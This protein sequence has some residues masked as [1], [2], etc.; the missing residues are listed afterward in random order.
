MYSKGDL[1]AD[2]FKIFDIFGGEKKSGFGVVYACFDIEDQ[3]FLALKTFQDKY[4]EDKIEKNNFKR[5]ALSWITL[6]KHPFIVQAYHYSE[7][8]YRPYI[9]L[10]LIPF[11]NDGRNILS[12]FLGFKHSLDQILKWAI[13]FCYG[14]EYAESKGI[15]PHL[16]IK[17]DNIMITPEKNIKITDFGLSKLLDIGK[18]IKKH[19]EDSENDELDFLKSSGQIKGALPWI[20]PE[21]FSGNS[22]IKS[23]IYSFGII[24]YQLIHEGYHPFGYLN[25]ETNVEWRSAH[26]N[27]DFIPFDGPLFPIVDKCLQ[28]DYDSRYNTFKDLRK[29]LEA[30]YTNEIE[31][32]LPV[33][34][35]VSELEIWEVRAKATS[36]YSLK[37]YD[38]AI[39]TCEKAIKMDSEYSPAHMLMGMVFEALNRID[40]AEIKY[41]EAI[42]L[43]PEYD[44]AYNNL[45]NI[46]F[47]K[48][49]LDEAKCEYKKAIILNEN[50]HM[51]YYNLGNIYHSKYRS[52]HLGCLNFAI[53]NYLKAI[54]INPRFAE[55]YCNLG[56]AINDKGVMNDSTVMMKFGINAYKKALK[57]KSNHIEAYNNLGAAYVLIN[58]NKEAIEAYE[59]FIKYAGSK[60]PDLVS[61]AKMKILLL[62]IPKSKIINPW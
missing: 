61:K 46:Y 7:F 3:N 32:S 48:G 28:K 18:I 27:G 23:D 26:E 41:K 14:M 1:I 43:N 25:P 54:S 42:D 38:E 37:L 56:L 19:N 35:E 39:E 20:A 10:E 5:E 59:N 24:L 17:P 16:D 21:R 33:I 31:E 45:G 50:F 15:T 9:I 12:D 55:A 34:P 62:S 60:Y 36:F 8:D 6:E 40:D 57:Y 4:L 29:E 30:V 44:E 22:N 58:K 52:G 13:Q 51:A 53:N 49:L 47:N 11:D 2:R